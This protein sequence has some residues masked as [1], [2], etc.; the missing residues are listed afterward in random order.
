MAL[1]VEL[2][3][4]LQGVDTDYSF[5]SMDVGKVPSPNVEGKAPAFEPHETHSRMVYLWKP[6]LD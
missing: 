1:D 6:P 2:L 4:P 3:H 5:T